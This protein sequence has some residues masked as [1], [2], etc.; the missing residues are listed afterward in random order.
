MKERN[1]IFR[2]WNLQEN[3]WTQE[4][5]KNIR[6]NMNIPRKKRSLNNQSLYRESQ[7]Y[8]PDMKAIK[9][10]MKVLMKNSVWKTYE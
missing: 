5:K 3:P 9:Q 1:G 7:D 2:E 8:Q 6:K 10:K 4:L